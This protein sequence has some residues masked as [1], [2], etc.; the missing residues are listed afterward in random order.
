[1]QDWPEGFEVVNPHPGG[2]WLPLGTG[3]GQARWSWLGHSTEGFSRDPRGAYAGHKAP[4]HG[5]VTLPSHP[6]SPRRKLCRV[7]LS[8]S[9]LALK[10]PGGTPETNKAREIQVEVE[11]FAASMAGLSTYD[12]DWLLDEVIWPMCEAVGDVS[13]M[14][15]F[16]QTYDQGQGI[17]LAS[18]NS[19]I[20]IKPG[21]PFYQ[22]HELHAHQHAPSN[23]HWDAPY[24][25]G[26]CSRRY[27]ILSGNGPTPPPDPEELTVADISTIL[28]KLDAQEAQVAALSGQVA[29]M[30][31]TI[32]DWMQG[33]R[34]WNGSGLYR[35]KG[36]NAIH[37]VRFDEDGLYLVRLS[38]QE[39]AFLGAAGDIDPVVTNVS[40]PAQIETFENLR[41][42]DPR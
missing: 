2:S 17:V 36:K 21:R 39:H 32:G 38:P 11:G 42:Y 19:P 6:Y 14:E 35:V 13:I 37:V 18:E 31:R 26:Y 5:W 40:D 4:P 15:T 1:M 29:A 9:A 34:V 30:Q 24:N 7:P 25:L 8:R 27:T 23:T 3:A 20:R 22:A 41:G 10:H 16:R 28:A 33:E 12:L